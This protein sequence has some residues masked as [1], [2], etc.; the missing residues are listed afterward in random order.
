MGDKIFQMDEKYRS[1][2]Y[3]KGFFAAAV[4]AERGAGVELIIYGAVFALIGACIF[5]GLIVMMMGGDFDL[6]EDVSMIVIDVSVNVV[7]GIVGL[8]FLVPG[9]LIIRF[10]IKRCRLGEDAWIQETAQASGYQESIIRDFANQAL[11][12]E[13]FILQ[14]AASG[15][16]GFLTRDYIYFY[17][18]ITK[19]EDIA[20]AY[21]VETSYTAN[22]NGKSKRM[23]CR[24][25]KIVSNHKTVSGSQAKENTVK[26]ILDM[27]W[28]KNPAIDTQ[29]GRLLSENEFDQKVEELG[30]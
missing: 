10:G 19:I 3:P 12:D 13:S 5:W 14:F 18:M 27:L 1:Q 15:V 8:V 29:G 30:K 16:K 17:K 23:Y 26:Q 28:Q 2:H 11:E 4:K 22:I 25:I 21:F 24:N 6:S 9:I 20:G 7:L